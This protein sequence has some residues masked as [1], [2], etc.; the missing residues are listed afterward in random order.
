MPPERDGNR[1]LAILIEL[2]AEHEQCWQENCLKAKLGPLK[3]KLLMKGPHLF[4]APSHVRMFILSNIIYTGADNV[5][6]G[7]MKR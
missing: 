4:D 7:L 6:N 2:L 1:D 3:T 5:I